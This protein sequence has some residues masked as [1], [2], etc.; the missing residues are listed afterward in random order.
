MASISG[1]VYIIIGAAMSIASAAINYQKMMV[2]F[3]AGFIFIGVGFAKLAFAKILPELRPDTKMQG[4]IRAQTL[5]QMQATRAQV[6]RQS[7]LHRYEPSM[8]QVNRQATHPTA[9]QH[10]QAAKN[11]QQ[12]QAQSYTCSSCGT[13]L[14]PS[15]TFC[16]RCGQKLK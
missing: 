4:E 7:A 16:P 3:Y 5:A 12:R 9:Q 15:F 10:T 1:W 13:R 14:H 2:F 8:Q 6:Q 11:A